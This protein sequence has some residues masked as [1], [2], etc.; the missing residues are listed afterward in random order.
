MRHRVISDAFLGEKNSFSFPPRPAVLG[1]PG[2]VARHAGPP[3]RGLTG[4]HMV[5]VGMGCAV[6]NRGEVLTPLLPWARSKMLSVRFGESNPFLTP[7][8][9]STPEQSCHVWPQ[10]REGNEPLLVT[11][12]LRLESTAPVPIRKGKEHFFCREQKGFYQTKESLF[13]P[14]YP[15]MDPPQRTAAKASYCLFYQI[16]LTWGKRKPTGTTPTPNPD[17]PLPSQHRA[18]GHFKAFLLL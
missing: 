7:G 17:P 1:F 15:E 10:R 2:S 13:P 8:R 3:S 12:G 9:H 11:V 5:L 18:V 4:C 16:F 6:G 14:L